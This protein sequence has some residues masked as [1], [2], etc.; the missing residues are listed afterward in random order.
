MASWGGEGEEWEDCWRSTSGLGVC[1]GGSDS[2]AMVPDIMTVGR[3]SVRSL[4]SLG[5]ASFHRPW[6]SYTCSVSPALASCSCLYSPG[7][8]YTVQHQV[9]IK[10]Q[11]LVQSVY[12]TVE[13]ISSAPHQAAAIY[14]LLPC[15]QSNDAHGE[16]PEQASR[17]AVSSC[18]PCRPSSFPASP[19]HNVSRRCVRPQ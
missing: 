18:P 9:I 19:T 4:A 16:H 13:G 14:S 3:G 17:V 10:R 8:R 6:G 2:V 12:I 15:C 1:I 7:R 5:P 11:V